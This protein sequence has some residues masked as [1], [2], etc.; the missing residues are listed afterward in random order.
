[1]CDVALELIWD[2]PILLLCFPLYFDLICIGLLYLRIQ[3]FSLR[4][5]PFNDYMD[6]LRELKSK[7]PQIKFSF[8]NRN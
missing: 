8:P 4:E 1:M 2:C 5:F 3:L 7:V 6:H